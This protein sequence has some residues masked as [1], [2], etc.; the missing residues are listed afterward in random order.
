MC[1][2]LDA[3]H[4]TLV[5]PPRRGMGSSSYAAVG[6]PGAAV[7]AGLRE[8]RRPLTR[9][10]RHTGASNWPL[11]G[12]PGFIGTAAVA[13]GLGIVAAEQARHGQSRASERF[14]FGPCR[15]RHHQGTEE[16]AV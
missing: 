13:S 7:A 11:G 15:V 6:L 2:I 9:R 16:V 14:G 3:H 8:R 5:G 4:P 12:L 1:R 10:P